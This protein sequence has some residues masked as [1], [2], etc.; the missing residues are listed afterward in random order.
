MSHNIGK[1]LMTAARIL[2]LGV[3]LLK[4]PLIAWGSTCMTSAQIGAG[5]T[6]AGNV[7]VVAPGGAGAFM[8]GPALAYL[9][10]V[11]NCSAL[12]VYVGE[13]MIVTALTSDFQNLQ[14]AMIQDDSM[15]ANEITNV[16]LTKEYGGA[17]SSAPSQAVAGSGCQSADAAEQF[18]Q[19]NLGKE[20]IQTTYQN[21]LSSFRKKVTTG[22]QPVAYTNQE[23]PGSFSSSTLFPST[24]NAAISGSSSSGSSSAEAS[25]TDAAHYIMNLTDPNPPP[26]PSNLNPNAPGARQRMASIKIYDA[27]MNLAQDAI[28]RVAAWNTGTYPLS[29]WLTKSMSGMGAPL[30]ATT[31][32]G[33]VSEHQAMA[34]LVD[35]RFQNPN[36]YQSVATENSSDLLREIAYMDA[37]SLKIELSDL[38]NDLYGLAIDASRYAIG[39][40]Q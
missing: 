28:S 40:K 14:N 32:S 1:K 39:L 9:G 21:A 34:A 22:T 3:F 24:S 29:G 12:S 10:Q 15:V 31:A 30:P 7:A 8:I 27:R 4:G 35:G 36:W 20:T 26:S 23:K 5:A 16:L 37:L 17:S 11:I 6:A 19:G 18:A 25:A 2:L 38:N 13:T 33:L